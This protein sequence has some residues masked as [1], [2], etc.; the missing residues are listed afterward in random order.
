MDNICIQ[1]KSCCLKKTQGLAIYVLFLDPVTQALYII[2]YGYI[3]LSEAY[4]IF[5]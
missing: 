3:T 2:V 1:R 4:G 5:R